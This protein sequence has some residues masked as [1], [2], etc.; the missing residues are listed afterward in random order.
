M[1]LEYCNFV[2]MVWNYSYILFS[3]F[4]FKFNKRSKK[5]F[6]NSFFSTSTIIKLI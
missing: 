1:Y 2:E 6:V 3:G 4:L 5:E